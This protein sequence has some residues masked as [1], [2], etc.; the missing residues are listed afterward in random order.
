[1]FFGFI[2]YFCTYIQGNYL[3]KNLPVMDGTW[4]DWSLYRKDRVQSLILWLCIGL[5][6]ILVA[7]F[8][9]N[10]K[11]LKYLSILSSFI[12]AV[13]FV[14]L[15]VL[16]T[17]NNG[18]IKKD[19]IATKSNEFTMSNDENFI[20]LVLDMYDSMTFKK[21]ID[22]KEGDMLLSQGLDQ[23]IKLWIN[24]KNELN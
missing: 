15:I 7:R 13:L 12:T 1:M 4:I 22:A 2:A 21:I 9:R 8:L 5:I 11:G 3:I 23:K 10:K 17:Q 24:K 19:V 20:I 16:S 18:Q 14:T 6:I